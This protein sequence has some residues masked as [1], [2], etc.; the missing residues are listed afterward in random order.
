M[1]MPDGGDAAPAVGLTPALDAG[2]VRPPVVSDFSFDPD[3][4]DENTAFT[5]LIEGQAFT[6]TSGR[7]PVALLATDGVNT[8]VGVLGSV[9]EERITGSFGTTLEAATW[10]VRVRFSD[11]AVVT[12]GAVPVGDVAPVINSFV[13]SPVTPVADE[14]FTAALTGVGF[15]NDRAPNAIFAVNDT[16]TDE[17]AGVITG[18]P[19]DT[20]T[21]V[22]FSSGLTPA[23][24]YHF[25]LE[26]DDATSADSDPFTIAA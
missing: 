5:V 7:R 26:F 19:T 12:A 3:P 23:N 21:N 4:L 16:T 13:L 20:N 14:A 1:R 25:R 11:S 10:A 22:S 18:S 15:L 9:S 17:T 24:D 2:A 6:N 8:V